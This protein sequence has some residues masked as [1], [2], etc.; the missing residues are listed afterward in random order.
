MFPGSAR[1]HGS[2]GATR[3]GRIPGTFWSTFAV[4]ASLHLLFKTKVVEVSEV[5]R[6]STHYSAPSQWDHILSCHMLTLENQ[7]QTLSDTAGDH[8]LWYTVMIHLSHC[9]FSHVLNISRTVQHWLDFVQRRGRD[10]V[11]LKFNPTDVDIYFLA[12][13][14]FCFPERNPWLNVWKRLKP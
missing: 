13:S 1:S 12:Y 7:V 10:D 11:C 14:S 9:V 4:Y 5:F 2:R 3:T 8:H 6:L